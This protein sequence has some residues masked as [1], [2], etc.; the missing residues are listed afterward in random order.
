[1]KLKDK[2]KKGTKDQ[3]QDAGMG[4]WDFSALLILLLYLGIEFVPLFDSFDVLGPQWVYLNGVNMLSIL[5]LWMEKRTDSARTIFGSLITIT[6]LLLIATMG[7]SILWAQN[8]VES[9]FSYSRYLTTAIMF[10]CIAMLI[11]DRMKIFKFLAYAAVIILVIQSAQVVDQYL[12]GVKNDIPFS[13]II[14]NLKLNVGNKNILAAT[15]VIKFPFI[16]YLILSRSYPIRFLGAM[17]LILATVAL[18]L[19]NARASF[20]SLVLI[21]IAYCIH[22]V[23]EYFKNQ[24]RSE[25]ITQALLV[26]IPTGIGILISNGLIEFGKINSDSTI[27]GTIG[28]RISSIGLSNETTG[29]RLFNYFSAID[30]IKNNPI[31]GCGVG[32]WKV[33]SI[34]YESEVSNDLFV[35][36]H[37]HNDFLEITA[38]TGLLGGFLFIAVFVLILYYGLLRYFRETSAE[39]RILISVILMAVG[40]YMVDAFLNFPLERPIMQFY[41]AALLAISVVLIQPV[42]RQIFEIKA[43]SALMIFSIT[44][45][46]LNAPSSYFNW[47]Y[48]R[49]LVA[50]AI[51]S[52][53]SLKG[54]PERTWDEVKDAFPAAPNINAF[55]IPIVEIKAK[56]LIKENRF[57]EALSLLNSADLVPALGYND[58]LKSFVYY[59]LNRKDSAFLLGQRAFFKRPRSKSYYELLAKFCI[60]RKDTATLGKMF[61]KIS[62]LR[63]EDW[64]W[65][66]YLIGLKESG[67]PASTLTSVL[68]K[69]TQ[70]HPGSEL[71]NSRKKNLLYTDQYQFAVSKAFEYYQKADYPN[72]IKFFTEATTLNPFDYSNFENIGLAYFAQGD[73]YNSAQWFEKVFSIRP[74][75]DGKAEYFTGLSLINQGD[76]EKGCSFLKKATDVN[77]NGASNSYNSLCR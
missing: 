29:G 57:N 20:V 53:D 73:Y 15:L 37:V 18:V 59:Q 51:F 67:A 44:G 71:L 27:Y 25:L 61:R 62:P 21:V 75:M 10:L 17:V 72:A 47:T 6:F 13:D 39:S 70:R 45:I 19:V 35:S 74:A 24:S 11:Y 23:L 58:F 7:L 5:F 55:C 36:Y 8:Q 52:F 56:Y 4:I 16:F 48:Y 22:L 43:K 64:V 31:L 12:D 65:D 60:E 69:A 76:K 33:A 49:S 1:M 38:E 3:V 30:Y 41:F 63:D 68:S 28:S 77:F 34:P 46:L 50:Q 40:C 2:N 66:L 54:A 9:M 42:A 32:N 14:L 26:L